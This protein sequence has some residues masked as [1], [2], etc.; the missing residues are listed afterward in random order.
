MNKEQ[1]EKLSRLLTNEISSQRKIVRN[2]YAQP[3][4]TCYQK[5]IY[6]SLDNLTP[7]YHEQYIT[8][9][10]DAFITEFIDH[11]YYTA[12]RLFLFSERIQDMNFTFYFKHKGELL[13]RE[14]EVTGYRHKGIKTIIIQRRD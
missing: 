10:L 11:L 2:A 7:D 9:R 8:G 3:I 1:E 14:L 5:D 6:F 12:L 4:I 13:A